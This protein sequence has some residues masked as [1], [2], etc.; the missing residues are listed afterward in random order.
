[1][2]PVIRETDFSAV[3]EGLPALLTMVVMP[4]TFSITNGVGAS[5]VMYT[6][7]KLAT[8]TARQVH[9]MMYLVSAT[10]VVYFALTF[11]Q[12]EFGW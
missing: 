1:M 12:R 4:F 5:F 8:G 3:E 6:F 9:W 11:I 7:L 2:A 10:F